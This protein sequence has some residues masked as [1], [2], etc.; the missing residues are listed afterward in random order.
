MSTW[1]DISSATRFGWRAVNLAAHT[2]R[3]V[4]SNLILPH[5]PDVER[6][7]DVAAPVRPRRRPPPDVLVEGQQVLRQDRIAELLELGQD[8]VREAPV[9]VLVRPGRAIASRSSAFTISSTSRPRLPDV[10]IEALEG[11]IGLRY[12]PLVLGRRQPETSLPRSTSGAS[13]AAAPRG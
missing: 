7:L 9:V 6:V 2:L 4:F 13:K 5:V 11:E 12:R 8:L 1:L 10:L 3:L